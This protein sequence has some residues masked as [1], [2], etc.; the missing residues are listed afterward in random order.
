MTCVS[1]DMTNRH[2]ENTGLNL[3]LNSVV[4]GDIQ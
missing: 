1:S 4:Y 3:G 2:I